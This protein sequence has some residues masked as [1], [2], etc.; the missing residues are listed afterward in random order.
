[1]KL[2]LALI[3]SCTNTGCLVSMVDMDEQVETRYSVLVQDRIMIEPNQLVT[4]DMSVDPPE[5]VWRWVRA[6]V[7][8][9]EDERVLVSG[10]KRILISHAYIQELNLDIAPDDE[11]WV[12]KVGHDCEVHDKIVEGKPEHPEQLLAY[13]EPII[14]SIYKEALAD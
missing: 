4:V 6:K 9:F 10:A 1:M 3:L 13:I 7:D 14:L 5:I 12:C 2:E 8:K 11:V